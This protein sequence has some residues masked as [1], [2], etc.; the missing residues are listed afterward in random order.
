MKPA[1]RVTPKA[2][3]IHPGVL[4]PGSAASAMPGSPADASPTWNTNAPCTGCESA[5]IARQ[6]TVYVPFASP[7]RRSTAMWSPEMWRTSPT[8]TRSSPASNTRTEPSAVSTC[9]LKRSSTLAG[10]VAT[11][12]PLAGVVSVRVA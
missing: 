8:S 6:A 12:E 11:T 9:S 7:P 1:N 4:D 10:A 3:S 2:G 5:E